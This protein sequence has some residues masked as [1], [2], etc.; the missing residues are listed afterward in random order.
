M[1]VNVSVTGVGPQA[2]RLRNLSAR[3]L[4][5]R[6]VFPA[7]ARILMADERARFDTR[8]FGR[9]P[10]LDPDTIR[11]KHARGQS[12]RVLQATG[13]LKAALTVM[14]APGQRLDIDRLELRFGIDR[15]GDAYYGQFH[16][17]GHG[18][19]KRTIISVTPRLRTQI[20]GRVRQ[21]VVRGT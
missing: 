15:Q 18:V 1:R 10:A 14:H 17:G 21:F 2:L 16:Q 11:R 3:M 12:E 13:R 9:W 5:A 20:S 19:P 7:V 8:G 6:P 4:D